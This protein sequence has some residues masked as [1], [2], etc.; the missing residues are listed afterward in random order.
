MSIGTGQPDGWDEPDGCEDLDDEG[1]WDMPCE[2]C[3]GTGETTT[4]VDS[5][6]RISFDCPEGGGTGWV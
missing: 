4:A 2:F 5:N 6:G 1:E 3:D